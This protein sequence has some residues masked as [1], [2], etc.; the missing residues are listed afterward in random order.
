MKTNRTLQLVDKDE[1]EY[2]ILCSEK[3]INELFRNNALLFIAR[4][5]Y[6]VERF[7]KSVC[8]CPFVR[9]PSVRPDLFWDP[10]WSE[11]PLV[12]PF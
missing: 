11:T 10:V 2:L 3:L 12:A 5:A 1:W 8:V 9:C 6:C 7:P 4:R